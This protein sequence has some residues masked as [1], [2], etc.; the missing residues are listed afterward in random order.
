[1]WRNSFRSTRKAFTVNIACVSVG[2]RHSERR[3]LA[4]STLV[5]RPSSPSPVWS[6]FRVRLGGRIVGGTRAS[7]AR[8]ARRTPAWQSHP[9]KRPSGVIRH[10]VMVTGGQSPLET[11]GEPMIQ[12]KARMT[13]TS[14]MTRTT[15]T[16]RLKS[17]RMS[18]QSGGLGVFGQR[19]LSRMASEYDP[20]PALPKHT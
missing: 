15:R 7:G 14:S 4:N 19:G 2:L 13:T 11:E 9:H 6:R 10:E 17:R 16:T 1:M 18:N 3:E 20:A 5:W 12:P 8:W